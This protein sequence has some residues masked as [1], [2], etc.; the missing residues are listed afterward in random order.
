MMRRAALPVLGLGCFLVLLLFC[1]RAVLWADGQFAGGNSAYFDYPLHARVQQEW[2]AGRWPLWDPGTNGGAPLLGNPVAAV[3]YPGKAV[4]ALLPYGWAARLYVMLHTILAFFGLLVLARTCGASWAASCLGALAYAFGAP[5]LCNYNNTVYLVGA[6]WAP[7]GLC[8]LDR[9]LRLGRRQAALELAAVLALQ[10]LGGDPEAAY[11]TGLCGAGY[12]LFLALRERS[13]TDQGRWWRWP[14]SR[15]AILGGVCLWAVAT[16]SLAAARFVRPGMVQTNQVVLAGWLAVALFIA[17][18]SFRAPGAARMARALAGL[19]GAGALAIALSA[20]QILPVLEFVGQSWRAGG[21][22][23]SSRDRYSLDPLRMVELVWPNVFG[24]SRPENRSWLQAVPPQGEH[25]LLTE[26]LYMGGPALFLALCAAGWRGGPAWR[27]WLTTVA[28]VALA[29]S[30][31]KYGSPLWWAR[32]LGFTSTFGPHDPIEGQARLDPFLPDGA[33]SPY[34]LMAALCPGFSAFRFP[35]KLVPLAAVGVAVL[36][37]A[38]WD[39]ACESHT[40]R[41]RLLGLAGLGLSVAALVLAVSVRGPMVAFLAART[42]ADLLFGP[43]DV[44][45]G[46]ALT[47][48]ALAHGAIGCTAVLVLAHWAP[49]RTRGASAVALVVVAADLA[50]ANAGLIWTVP[51]RDFEIPSE[52]AR[53]IETAERAQPSAGPFRVH[54]MPGWFPLGFAASPSEK[55]AREVTEWARQTLQPLMG[56][57][58]SIEYCLTIGSLE[59]DDYVAFF[60]P[61]AMPVPAEMARILGVPSGQPITYFPR[62]SFDLWG[63]RYFLL[64]AAPVWAST[65]RG[66]ASFLNNTE[67]IHPAASTLYETA[68][69]DA[70]QTWALRYDWQLRRNRAAYPRAWVVHNAQVRPPAADSD[71]R[72]RRLRTLIYLNDPIWKE[73]GRPV[74][75]ARQAA[76]IE[77]DTADRLKGFLS[78]TPVGPSESVTIVRHHPQRVELL[79]RLEQPGLVILADTYY[80]GWQLTIDGEPAPIFRANRMMRGAAVR[81]GEHRL[82]YSYR[83]QSFRLGAMISAATLILL[84]GL[85]CWFR[86]GL[87]DKLPKSIFPRCG[88]GP[89]PDTGAHTDVSLCRPD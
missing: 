51:Q 31:G 66:Y 25:E 15:W 68:S 63:A 83:P 69:T 84:L 2:D 73:R 67:L 26:S 22:P 39:R 81:A 7:W 57:P 9:F 48:R 42:P 20:V 17:W 40:P 37:G 52:A 43:A 77:T 49:R 80:P 61:R 55:R 76:L 23:E 6:A 13:T 11:L 64:P 74:F 19:A 78:R 56:L 34:G 88:P 36:A 30:F 3:L 16:L 70:R 62:R 86:F 58:L 33:G 59:M 75:D 28:V 82:V 1:Y 27:A 53:L 79:A 5:V 47:Q 29:A 14:G 85:G 10:I 44:A 65:S 35:A 46:W 18:R 50:V 4:Y 41:L 24:S 87:L 71:T 8:A 89:P 12:A 21:I 60:Q 72:A 32:S 45:R 38:G 54:R